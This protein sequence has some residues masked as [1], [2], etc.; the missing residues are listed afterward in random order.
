MGYTTFPALEREVTPV[1]GILLGLLFGSAQLYLLIVGVESLAAGRLKIWPFLVQF[2]CPLA[3]LLLCAWLQTEQLL[4]CAI[5][6]SAVLIL[7]AVVKFL[8]IRSRSTKGKK[9]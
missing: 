6:M 4:P 3:G 9:D 7:G 5:A 2:F 1:I 8:R